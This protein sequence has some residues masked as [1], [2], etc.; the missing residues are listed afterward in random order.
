MANDIDD[1]I[2]APY[3]SSISIFALRSK[4]HG[5][6]SEFGKIGEN[7]QQWCRLMIMNLYMVCFTA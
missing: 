4:S 3:K 5:P 7:T 2:P 1:D 6:L